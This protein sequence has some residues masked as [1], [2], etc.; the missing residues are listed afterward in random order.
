M[1]SIVPQRTAY[2]DLIPE[3]EVREFLFPYLKGSHRR[4]LDQDG[5]SADHIFRVPLGGMPTDLPYDPNPRDPVITPSMTKTF[6]ASVY[7]GNGIPSQFHRKNH[8]IRGFAEAVSVSDDFITVTLRRGQGLSDGGRTCE[9]IRCLQ[10][11]GGIPA[12]AAVEFRW[13]TGAPTDWYVDLSEGLNTSLQVSDDSLAD[14]R[15]E[16]DELK[17]A[18]DDWSDKVAWHQGEVEKKVDAYFILKRLY[19]LNVYRFPATSLLQPVEAYSGRT[20]VLEIFRENR[21]EFSKLFP[22][23]RDA[24]KFEEDM[25]MTAASHYSGSFA[26]LGIVDNR[27]AG[28]QQHQLP[29]TG[30][31]TR[32]KLQVAAGL[33]MLA[34]H[35]QLIDTSG[36]E[37]SWIGG[38]TSELYRV[39]EASASSLIERARTNWSEFDGN[40]QTLGKKRSHW[41]SL[42]D[43]VGMHI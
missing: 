33:P 20:R 29:F 35:R 41:Q 39:W 30:Q 9:I 32:T 25:L 8:G 19:V 36:S 2:R 40:L 15:G 23:L 13:T 37:A 6:E 34:A 38:D 12:T 43:A 21:D 42:F 28:K 4:I 24:L 17:A 10:H 16:F 7:G 31:R 18:L 14:A 22:I 27:G 1:P 26:A 5:R 3:G 11:K